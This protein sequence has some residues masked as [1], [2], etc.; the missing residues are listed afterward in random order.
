M[1]L[2]RLQMAIQRP[3][4]AI[5]KLHVANQRPQVTFLAFKK[6]LVAKVFR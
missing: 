2:Q 6:S 5:Q 1:A 3:Q 4:D